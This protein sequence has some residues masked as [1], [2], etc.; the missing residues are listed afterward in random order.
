MNF[1]EFRAMFVGVQVSDTYADC[2]RSTMEHPS[3]AY[4]GGCKKKLYKIQKVEQ[5]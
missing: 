4:R 5:G 3:N 1:S 2:V